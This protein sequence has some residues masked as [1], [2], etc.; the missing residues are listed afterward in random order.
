[1]EVLK[2]VLYYSDTGK[3]LT[4][5]PHGETPR[6]CGG[7]KI[8]VLLNKDFDIT[9]RMMVA[10]FKTPS[11][12][13]FSEDHIMDMKEELW[14]FHKLPGE[15]VG[16]LIDKEQYRLFTVDLSNTYANKEAG[17]LD[18]TFTIWTND[19]QNPPSLIL[20]QT[21]ALG[22]ATI[23][24]EETLGLAPY[25]GV[26]MTYT[27]YQSLMAYLIDGANLDNYYT[28]EESNERFVEKE[29]TINDMDIEIICN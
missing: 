11:M 23:F 7:L 20:N 9:N 29:S 25:S 17:K 13:R 16:S 26:G 3:L 27:E 6:Q 5:I 1:M 8:F 18:I 4:I 14:T 19:G 15:N 12:L 22:K 28:K 2:M 21:I 10:R 24:V